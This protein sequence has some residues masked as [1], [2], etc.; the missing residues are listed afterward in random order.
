MV[1]HPNPKPLKNLNPRTTEPE[2]ELPDQATRYQ[3]TYRKVMLGQIAD[4]IFPSTS[5]PP[6]VS[7]EEFMLQAIEDRGARMR[8]HRRP[9]PAIWRFLFLVILSSI[10][11]S[12]V[13]LRKP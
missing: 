13:L 4:P 11:L 8:N 10:A 2:T 12:I 3:D 5:Q 1:V 6:D 7:E 9:I